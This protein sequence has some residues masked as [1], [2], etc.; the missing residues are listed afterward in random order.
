MLNEYRE[1]A[2]PREE[3]HLPYAVYLADGR[4]F[5]TLAL[6]VD[7]ADTDC[8]EGEVLAL[9]RVLDAAGVQW[10]QARSVPSGHTHLLATLTDPADHQEMRTVAQALRAVARHLDVTPLL[11]PVTGCIRPPGSPHRAG[12]TSRLV[13]DEA[14]GLETLKTG[15]S[16]HAWRRL[17]EWARTHGP[18]RP[19]PASAVMLANLPIRGGYPCLRTRKRALPEDMHCLLWDGDT[20]GR[21]GGNRSAMAMGITLSLQHAGHTFEQYRVLAADPAAQG[22]DHLR[23]RKTRRGGFVDRTDRTACGRMWRDALRFAVTRPAVTRVVDPTV[24]LELARIAEAVLSASWGGQPG[25]SNRAVMDAMLHRGVRLRR[26]EL[27]V[28][29][30][31]LASDAGVSKST[32]AAALRRLSALGWVGVVSGGTGTDASTYRL[33]TPSQSVA[34]RPIEQADT[35]CIGVGRTHLLRPPP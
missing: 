5:R 11:N 32:A 34:D 14:H 35:G 6:D 8:R 13:G 25:T 9:A 27:S 30:R 17:V 7:C 2:W 15:T 28:S 4:R 22:L 20:A 21:Y 29:V 10:V 12:G 23:L 18:E 33:M 19:R 24:Y 3:P 16:P 1:K 26:A 31:D